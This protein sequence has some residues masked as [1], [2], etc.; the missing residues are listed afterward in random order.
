[1]TEKRLMERIAE[2]DRR[3]WPKV[4][5]ILFVSLNSF[6]ILISKFHTI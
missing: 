4:T 3:Q 2:E 6:G 5:N 1:L